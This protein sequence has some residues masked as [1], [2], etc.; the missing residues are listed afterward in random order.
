MSLSL[1]ALSLLV[2]LSL[3][4]ERFGAAPVWVFASGAAAI[5]PLGA[6]IRRATEQVAERAGPAIGG[7]MNVTFGNAAEFILALFVLRSGSIG[8]VKATIT[9]S[10]IGNSLLGLGLAI[11]AGSVGRA[12]QTFQRDRAG[13]LSSLLIL[14]VNA[15]LLPAM[16]DYA[17]R[18][19]VGTAREHLLDER[20]SLGVAIV[21]ILV[22]AANL[23]YTLV[24]HRDIFAGSEEEGSPSWSLAKALA[25]LGAATA[26]V[27]VEA[28]LVS[29]ALEPTAASPRCQRE[30]RGGAAVESVWMERAELA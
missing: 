11:L 8:V 30:T 20:L 24:T 4:L 1:L 16:F 9:G 23:F 14:S 17:E 2:P 13:L 15:L 12:K 6:W 7:L 26:G 28:E 25:V 22:Y 5:V 18:G 21:L 3:A 27:A 10:I 19:L 29:G